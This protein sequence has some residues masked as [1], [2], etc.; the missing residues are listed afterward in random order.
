MTVQCQTCSELIT[1]D[2]V[3]SSP[4]WCPKC[5]ADLQDAVVVDGVRPVAAARSPR[6]P[7]VPAPP[8]GSVAVPMVFAGG[9]LLFFIGI[10]AALI[11]GAELAKSLVAKPPS[12]NQLTFLSLTAIGILFGAAGSLVMAGTEHINSGHMGVLIVPCMMT[13]IT[14]VMAL[15]INWVGGRVR[16]PDYANLQTVLLACGAFFWAMSGFWLLE[17]QRRSIRADGW[18]AVTWGI[19]AEFGAIAF[20]LAAAP[21]LLHHDPAEQPDTS[22][23]DQQAPSDPATT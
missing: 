17:V 20:A 9:Y 13:P 10:M 8:K 14:V 12:P 2:E 6:M 1:H 7:A 22:P 15:G 19:V 21:R 18:Q 3:H 5:G 4:P 11:G 16:K 23:S